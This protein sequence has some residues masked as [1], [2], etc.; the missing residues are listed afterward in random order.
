MRTNM[1]RAP[2]PQTPEGFDPTV[3]I[4]GVPHTAYAAAQHA[5]QTPAAS[6]V[7]DDAEYPAGWLTAADRANLGREPER[8]TGAGID[9]PADWAR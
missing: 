6:P 7:A 3:R 8:Q 1:F 9:Y 2:R 5:P 4:N